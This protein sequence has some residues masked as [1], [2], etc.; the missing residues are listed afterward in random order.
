MRVRNPASR[1]SLACLLM[2]A[3]ALPLIVWTITDD[4]SRT[5]Q[6][7]AFCTIAAAGWAGLLA[8]GRPIPA[9]GTPL[10]APLLAYA[11]VAALLPLFAF[12]F[13]TAVVDGMA[14]FAGVATAALVSA[15]LGNKRNLGRVLAMVALG[16]CAVAVYGYYQYMGLD[17]AK[18]AY[19][20]G[21]MHMRPFAT[22][23]NPNF[24]GGHFAALLCWPVALFLMERDA[25]KKAGWFMLAAAWGSLVL[26]S[27]TRGSWLAVVVALAWLAFMLRRRAPEVFQAQRKWL[28]GAAA[29]AAVGALAFVGTN[30]DILGRASL[31][32]HPEFGQVAKRVTALK[33]AAMMWR[34]HPLTGIGPGC[35]KHGY[36]RFLA[37][38]IP[39]SEVKQFTHTYS[40]EYAHCDP[41]QLLAET[42]VAGWGIFAWLVICSVR[43]L[44]RRS[45]PVVLAVLGGGV[46][47]LV[48]G[49]F[50]LPMHIAPTSF[51]F[52]LG[53]G[54]AAP[55]AP[56]EDEEERRTPRRVAIAALVAVVAGFFAVLIFASS[57]CNRRGNDY[58]KFQ[59]WFEAQQFFEKGAKLDWD[60]RREYFFIASMIFQRGDYLASIP[61]FEREL[62]RNPYYMDGFANLGSA[63][64]AAGNL[65]GAEIQLRTAAELNP[66]YAEA[67]A[68]LGVS[69]LQQRRY[70]DADESFGKA[71]ELEPD[72]DLAKRGQEEARAKVLKGSQR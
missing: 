31:L 70:R 16:N 62:T 19:T 44:L 10:A 22:L 12:R 52:W 18:W 45:T 5:P 25:G 47:L 48:H 57:V 37:R 36:G 14:V 39:A 49:S 59:R 11:A 53:V 61:Y 30:P 68:N 34:Q 65:V 35:F 58:V 29:A 3:G 72:L 23:G 38:S 40:E 15:H 41:V 50:N 60:D 66:A 32:W 8:A 28:I 9:A 69:L 4:T 64:G 43:L 7:A 21:V 24:L 71:L 1:F 13:T 27:Q 55:G 63:L 2:L 56:L 42:G 20:Y 26:V 17:K 46:A 33:S 6:W 67:Y 54:L 51:L